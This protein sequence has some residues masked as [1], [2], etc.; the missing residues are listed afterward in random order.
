MLLRWTYRVLCA[1]LCCIV[2]SCN[3]HEWPEYK[4]PIDLRLNFIFHTD[5]PQYLVI[6]ET[7]SRSSTSPY[8]YDVRY[9]V[10]C[11]KEAIC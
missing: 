4:G 11:I 5:L 6:D 8:D 7:L 1:M 2:C 3:V 10:D 9:I